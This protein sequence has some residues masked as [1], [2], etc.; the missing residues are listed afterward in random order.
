MVSLG[1]ISG[2][3]APA[4]NLGAGFGRSL[5]GAAVSMAGNIGSTL[6][7]YNLQKKLLKNQYDEFF[8]AARRAGASPAAIAQGVTG[9]GAASTP[10]VT[11]G[12][13]MPDI[14][15]NANTAQDVQSGVARR[16]VENQL[17]MMRLIYE[18]K[19]FQADIDKA[20]SEVR[21][22]VYQGKHYKALADLNDEIRH[23]YRVLRPWQI[24]GLSQ[25]LQN[26]MAEYSKILA[27]T[28][29]F[30][31]Q[32]KY[33]N[34]A[35]GN[36]DALAYKA[37]NEGFNAS[38]E[39]FGIQFDNM[40]RA[41]GINPNLR[42]WD[43][44]HQAA[45]TNPEAFEGIMNNLISVTNKIDD[46]IKINLGEHYKRNIAIGAGLVGGYKFFQGRKDKTLQRL[47]S[48][49]RVIGNIMPLAHP[50]TP[51]MYPS[52]GSISPFP[53]YSNF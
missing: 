42:P 35:A 30:K 29:M 6:I 51:M 17:D 40:L 9:S 22:N 4:S 53:Y 8:N 2:R 46:R 37:W 19:K 26:Q 7:N 38:L 49:T 12:S 45:M 48:M 11:N 25:G 34:S 14:A 36:Q 1:A 5:A 15:A 21:L 24:A 23:N 33:Y 52:M 10:S 31:A 47:E 27:E 28:D 39:S 20:F 3:P 41:N 16:G 32:K 50:S 44:L 43:A 18:P 13:P